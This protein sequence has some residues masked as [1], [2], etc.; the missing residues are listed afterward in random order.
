MSRIYY[1]A[2]AYQNMGAFEEHVY[3]IMGDVWRSSIFEPRP[4]RARRFN[5]EASPRSQVEVTPRSL[6]TSLNPLQD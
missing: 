3:Q 1:V 2:I 4:C 5:G 6:S